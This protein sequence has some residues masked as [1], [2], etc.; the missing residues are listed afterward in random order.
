[1][2]ELENIAAFVQVADRGS[3]TEAAKALGV[4]QPTVSRRVAELE[5]ALESAL[6]V[7]TTRSVSLTDAGQ[8]YLEHARGV[9]EQ[10]AESRDVVRREGALA[11]ELRLTAA[12]SLVEHVLC[13]ELPSFLDKYPRV[14]V[15]MNLTERHLDLAAERIDV[16]LRVGGPDSADLAGRRLRSVERWLVASSA[17]VAAHGMPASVGALEGHT[18]LVF[19]AS[20]SHPR[21][22][23]MGGTWVEPRRVLVCTSGTPLKALVLSGVG[24]AVLPDWMVA[25]D[26][27][28]GR[29]IRLLPDALSPSLALWLV[30]PRHRYQRAVSRALVDWATERLG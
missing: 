6:V 22:W 12:S 2:N 17:W 25:E 24:V 15:F 30:W 3:F 8:R 23:S 13:L 10:V 1:M 26:V 16:A 9:L 7:R 19:A 5:E 28:S 11:G 18:G 20:D 27:A 14:D 29:L 4:R 21:G